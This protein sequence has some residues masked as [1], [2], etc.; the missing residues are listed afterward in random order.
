M[1]SPPCTQRPLALLLAALLANGCALP[2]NATRA[3]GEPAATH[4]PRQALDERADPR[5]R[6]DDVGQG[7][8]FAR[9]PTQPGTYFSDRTR[10]AVQRYY[11]AHPAAGHARWEIG[12][13][14]P[15]G[16]KAGPVPHAIAQSLPRLPPGHRYGAVAG[17]IL[18]IATGSGIV[19]DGISAV[20]QQGV[21]S[22]RR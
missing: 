22:T 7:T 20:A 3:A 10:V 21:S 6:V 12:K 8:H 19:V 17:D 16:E 13:P 15:P 18:L 14:L 1:N 5:V 11:V 4:Q 9:K 2:A